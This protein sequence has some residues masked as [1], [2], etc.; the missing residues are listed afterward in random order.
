[1]YFG[2]HVGGQTMIITNGG[3]FQT[4]GTDYDDEEFSALENNGNSIIITGSNSWFNSEGIADFGWLWCSPQCQ[5]NN[6]VLVTN[7]GRFW[8]QQLS[9][10]STNLYYGNPTSPGNLFDLED[11]SLW[12]GSLTFSVGTLRVVHGTGTIDQ[13]DMNGGSNAVLQVS[14]NLWMGQHGSISPGDLAVGGSNAVLESLNGELQS[15]GW[16][17]GASAGDTGSVTMS[18]S[19]PGQSSTHSTESNSWRRSSACQA[20]WLARSMVPRRSR[21]KR[22]L[23]RE[24][25]SRHAEYS[26]V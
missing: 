16:I 26:R 20:F 4:G 19:G 7:G 2:M 23:K 9:Y 8:A 3:Y 25:V 1:M 14:G 24:P 22:K 6:L 12:I 17:I 10:G 11:G 21:M 15:G 5:L 18:K 13:M